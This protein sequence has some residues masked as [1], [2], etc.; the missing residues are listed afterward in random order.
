MSF[1][2][3]IVLGCALSAATGLTAQAAT[4]VYNA[5]CQ[6]DV[7]QSGIPGQSVTSHTDNCDVQNSSSFSKIQ[8]SSST[9]E[10]DPFTGVQGSADTL[11]EIKFFL[12]NSNLPANSIIPDLYIAVAY[13]VDIA[14]APGGSGGGR[15]GDV[16]GSAFGVRRPFD[17]A[18][19][20]L[21]TSTSDVFGGNS[22]SNPGPTYPI[23]NGHYTGT[24]LVP[25]TDPTRVN[26][27]G[28][29]GIGPNTF[30]LEVYAR[31]NNN[32]V[33]DAFH[34]VTFGGT[35]LPEGTSFS[36]ADLDGNPLSLGVVPEPAT[37]LLSVAALG[38]IVLGRLRF[39]R[40]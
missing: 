25:L 28:P 24:A 12:T 37:G 20:F 1:V 27:D 7:Q 3:R 26:S 23:C 4:I 11:I 22:C 29:G 33:T 38:V 14:A 16:T 31:S 30:R 32:A 15:P 18:W 6:S 19:T 5:I 2:S 21:V 8:L 13:D 35:S 40:R 39:R 34:T 10:L 17:P 36:Y 9:S